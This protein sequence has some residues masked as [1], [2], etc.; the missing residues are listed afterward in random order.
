MIDM[1]VLK[2]RPNYDPLFK[3]SFWFLHTTIGPNS[4]ISPLVQVNLVFYTAPYV[5]TLNLV[6]LLLGYVV[7]YTAS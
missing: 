6:L 1:L 5:L 2:I 7:S 3:N 4:Q